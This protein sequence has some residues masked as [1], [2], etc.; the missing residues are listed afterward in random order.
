[1]PVFSTFFITTGNNSTR[2]VHTDVYRATAGN[3]KFGVVTAITYLEAYFSFYPYFPHLL[4]D[5]IK[6]LHKKIPGP[7]SVVGI[8]TAYGLDCPGIESRWGTRYSAPLRTGPEAHPTSC[9]MGTG[10]F[11]GGKLRPGPDTDLSPPSSAEVKNIVYLYL[12]SP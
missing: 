12:C 2:H 8:A 11:P 10:S 1:V 9:K 4:P 6:I 7:V 3:V 5:M